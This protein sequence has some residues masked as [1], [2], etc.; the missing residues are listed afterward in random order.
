MPCVKGQYRDRYQG[1]DSEKLLKIDY[2]KP[3]ADVFRDLS[4]FMIQ[5]G[6]LSHVLCFVTD[7][8]DGLPSWATTWTTTL[9]ENPSPD[10]LVASRL[11]N[12][13]MTYMQIYLLKGIE[14]LPNPLRLL[15]N[16]C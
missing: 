14:P 4:I 10:G 2:T 5:G 11:S 16:L 8:M 3:V 12:G 13:I 6:M 9:V 1:R 15:T 7:S